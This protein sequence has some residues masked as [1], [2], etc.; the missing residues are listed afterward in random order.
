MTTNELPTNELPE[1]EE[2]LF[3]I[4][5]DAYDDACEERSWGEDCDDQ[6]D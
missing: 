6:R 2:S 5:L 3:G 1:V 4:D